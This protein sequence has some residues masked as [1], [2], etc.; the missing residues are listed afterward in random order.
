MKKLLFFLFAFISFTSYAQLDR[1]HWF[2]PMVDRANTGNSVQRIYMSTN[3]TV[4][5]KVDVYNNNTVI[6]TV[7][8]SKNNPKYYEFTQRDLIIVSGGTANLNTFRPVNKGVYLK[9]EKPFYSSL[10]FSISQHGELLTSK[11]TAGIGTEFRAVMAPITANNGILN[12]MTSVMATEDNTTVT[13]SNFSPGLRFSDGIPRTQINFILNKGQSYIIDGSGTYTQNFTGFIGAKIVSDKPISITNGNFNG[14]YATNATNSSDI[15][16]DQGVPIDRLGQEFVLMKGNGTT[17]SGMERAIVVAT[18]DNTDIYINGGIVPVAT[19]NA[20]QNYLTDNSAYVDQ[21]FDHYNMRIQTNKNAYVYQLLAGDAGSS[22]V[23]TG[24]FNYIPPLS[25]YLPIKI[26]EI[27]LIDENRVYIN[28]IG[29]FRD[30]IPT[31]L[32]II[33]ERGATVDVKRNGTSMVLSAANG[34]FNVAGNNN[35]VT[36][37]ITGVDGNIAVNSTRAVTAGISAGDDAVGYGGYFAGFSFIPAII[38]SEGDCLPGVKLEVTEGF[39]NYLWVMKVGA[40]YVPAPGINNTNKYEPTQAGI[41]AVQIQQGSCPQIQTQDF[42]FYNCTTYTNYNYNSCGTETITPVFALSSQPVDPATVKIVT[43]PTKGTVTIAPDGKF[44]YKVNPGASGTDTFK[45]SF[46]GIGAIPDCETVQITVIMIE[47]SDNVILQECSTTGIATYNL[48]LAAVSPDTDI[49][50]TYFKTENGAANDIAA[51]QI[52]GFTSYTSSDG[53][54]Y[55]RIKN[56]LGCIAVAKVELK[57]KLAPE[58]K[59]NLYTKLHC[60][61]DIDGKIDGTYKVDLATITPTVLVQ[62]SNF[63]VKYYSDAAL[64]NNITGIYSFTG[65]SSIWIKV[66]APNGCSSVI[67]E[68][69]LKTGAK[70]ALT[71]AA[72]TEKICDVNNDNTETINL[73][74]YLALFSTASGTSVTY[75]NTAAD[76]QNN[77]NAISANPIITG[78]RTFYYRI[79]VPG[80]CANIA[81]L[82]ILFKQGTP[83][84]LLPASVKVCQGNSTTLDVGTGYSGITWST[85]ATTQSVSLGA[86][87]YWVDLTN[88]LGCVYRQNVTVA[89]SPR[90][91]VNT[92]AY[93]AILCDSNF[94]GVSDTVN[95]NKITPVIITNFAA[96]LGLFTVRYYLNKSDR[97]AGNNNT[98]PNLTNWSFSTDTT[99]YV[100]VESQYCSYVPDASH[101]IYF[102]LGTSLPLITPTVLTTVCDND[103]NGTENISLATFRNQFTTDAA[104]TVSYFSSLQNAQANTPNIAVTQ[105]ITADQTFYYRFKKTGFCD[106]IGTLK[107]TF[108]AATPTALLDSYTVCQGSA[109]TL[110]AESSY[111]S[112][113]WKKG[114][115]TVSTSNTANLTAGVYT[116]FF[117][118]AS[119]CTFTKNITVVDSPKPAWNIA[120]YNATHCDDDFDGIIKIDFSAVTPVILPNHSLFTVEYFADTTYTTPLPSNW[121]YSADTKVYIRATSTV[122]PTEY[123][124][125]DFKLGTSLPLTSST[126]STTV[127]DND[128]SGSE[129][130]SLTDFNSLFTTSAGVSVKYFD[131]L[132]KA[133]NNVGG[134]DIT[135]AQTISGD[136]TFYYRLKKTGFCDVIGT[137]NIIFKQPKKSL[138][139]T[140]QKICPGTKV[141]LDAGPGFTAYLWSTGE[142]TS[143]ISAPVGN[144]WVD[145]SFNGCVYRQEVSVTAVSLPE[146]VSVEIQGSTVT[147]SVTGGNPPYQYAIDGENYQTS[148]VFTNVPGGDHTVYVI[149]ADNCAPVS[150][151]INVIQ[152]YNAITPNGDGFND[153][154]DYSGLLKKNEPFLQIF[155]RYGKTVFIG[156]KNNRFTW[157]GKSSGKII[158]TGS[159]WYV[160]HWKEPGFETVSKFTGWVLVKNRE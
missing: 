92:A 97:D 4:P 68:I 20:G 159:Y 28:N 30:K 153:V 90:P 26:D 70:A 123:R 143:S 38:K 99:V 24:G 110:T 54:I 36:Y 48:S 79:N 15:L 13:V 140:D 40:A 6:G 14:Q 83:S 64:S 86:G 149:S 122:C 151:D 119:G 148:N 12:F 39:S 11:G 154:L 66:D 29:G 17:T 8:I 105:T 9:G 115:T 74:D 106:V 33:T 45:M 98:I 10:R 144:Y 7:T 47:K 58:V 18:E 3:E 128:I 34:P 145:L 37:S 113:L 103:L 84:A 147:V 57:S 50:K 137:L 69:Q 62:A 152:L 126:V 142:T 1:E 52:T 157:D 155:D 104:A 156:D 49:T 91:I 22:M 125:I 21:G 109:V 135:T 61:E 146:I 111:S 120:A 46:C 78:D 150:A 93:S 65:N 133:Q 75:F 82:N 72:A 5:F 85:G 129:N 59:E 80:F 108:K 77:Q 95:F 100:R 139:L 116:V 130:I 132:I 87:N 67:K 55:V 94:D 138:V 131:T 118:N 136:Q 41:Y 25:C 134:E 16:M 44:T 89:D 2:A 158:E 56:S 32:N 81:T 114:S 124:Q 102:K 23:A 19:I 63:V 43:P 160:M 127:C 117:T 35:W 121:T 53:F 112:W 42:K 96:N 76:A 101:E 51:E 73:S 60:D 107:I 31:K 141:T 71:A 88:S 27:G